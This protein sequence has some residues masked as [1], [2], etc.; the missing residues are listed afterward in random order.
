V[1]SSR[2]SA[3]SACSVE[4]QLK[5]PL[6]T[7]VL[8]EATVKRFTDAVIQHYWYQ[9]YIDDLPLWGMVGELMTSQSQTAQP[10][11]AAGVEQGFIYTHKRLTITYNNNQ[12]IAV[13]LHSQEPRPLVV[14]QT[15]AFTF[16]VEWQPTDASFE[17]RFDRSH[18]IPSRLHL[19]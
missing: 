18:P 4:D 7:L 2:S 14:G 12:I 13:S 15:L 16:S 1:H 11:A 5:T 3:H 19:F 17:H 10:T 9:M 8:D 6:C